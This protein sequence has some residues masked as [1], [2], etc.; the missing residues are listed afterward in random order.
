MTSFWQG[1]SVL[2]TGAG[3][4][5]G[6]H[7]VEKLHAEGAKVRAFV[8]YNS[9]GDAGL[10]RQLPPETLSQLEIIGGDIRDSSAILKASDG[11]DVIFHLGA[12]ISIPYSY[13]H[14]REVTESNIIGTL[15]LLEAARHHKTARVIHTSTSEVY[16]TAQQVPIAETHPL[17]GQSPYAASKIGADKIAES[18]YCAYDTPIATVRPF[19]TYGPRQSARAVIPTIITQALTQDVIR[20]TQ[21][22]YD[23]YVVEVAG[24]Q[25]A[26]VANDIATQTQAAV[27]TSQWYADQA[28]QRTEQWQGPLSFLWMWCL[29]IFIVLVAGLVLWG[30]WSWLTGQQASQPVVEDQVD[31]VQAPAIQVIHHRQEELPPGIEGDVVDSRSQLIKPDNQVRHWLDEVKRKLL[32]KDQKD[33]HTDQ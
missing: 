13:V 14:P 28:R 8:R 23:L 1:K 18:F 11:A 10:L 17:Q 20:Q 3:G 19:N 30:L 16:G 33:E 9:R 24:T 32:S 29:P 22:Q 6:S 4:F 31:E 5:I 26:A 2:V 27:A 12:L 25:S 15:N 7:L 21:V